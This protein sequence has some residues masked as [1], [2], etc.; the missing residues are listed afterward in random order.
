MLYIFIGLYLVLP[1]LVLLASRHLKIIRTLGAV[2]W[3]YIL[4]ILLGNLI[5]LEALGKAARHSSEVS[6]LLAIPMLL[7]S[8]NLPALTKLAR[9]TIIS[10]ALVLLSVIVVSFSSFFIFKDQVDEASKLAGMLVGVFTGGTPNMVAIGLAL[11][12]K[13]EAFILLNAADLVLGGLFLLFLMTFGRRLFARLLPPFHQEEGQLDMQMTPWMNLETKYKF[14]TVAVSV[15]SSAA[16]VGASVG[17]SL[18]LFKSIEVPFVVLG[19]T[20]LGIAPSFW[21]KWREM[22]GS[23]ETGQYLLLVF[24]ISIGSL[25]NVRE[26]FS[27]SATYFI[28]LGT[29]LIGSFVLHLILCKLFKI[30]RD[31][32]MITSVAAIYGPP[33]VAPFATM[34]ENKQL[35]V[36]GISCG[37]LGYAL[38]NYLGIGLYY[39]ISIIT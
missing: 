34:L 35:L 21:K 20:A 28:F 5:P 14:L 31:T 38:G 27:A 23:Y 39:L 13:E 7:F 17:A 30:N 19:L 33:F 2:V 8:T 15:L 16:I 1:L 22:P 37:L 24:C 10:F 9:Q 29:I 11:K 25:A 26:L 36:A 3:C 18:W 12:V 32:A 4:G 6:V